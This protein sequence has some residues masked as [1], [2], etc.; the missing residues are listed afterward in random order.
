M[1]TDSP[2]ALTA[3]GIVTALGTGAAEVWPRLIEGDQSGLVER[4]D[5]VPGRRMVAAAV[6]D[7][8]PDVGA[9]LERYRCRNNALALAA[10]HQ[11]ERPVRTMLAAVGAERVAV[12][13]GS[14]TAGVA[15]AETAM[16]DH[17]ATGELPS[18]FHYIQFEFG[19]V[20]E[21]VAEW[22]GA[23]GPAY[24]IST[25]CS[26]SAKAIASARSLLRLG[27]CDAAI[28]GGADSLCRLTAN[29]FTALQAISE[30]PCN[31]F[32]A[33][34][35][36]LT[37]GEGAAIFLL[38]RTPGGIQLLGVGEATEAYHMSAP[39]PEGRGAEGAMRAALE[40]AGVEPPAIVYVNLHGTGT[41]LNDAME[42]KAVSRVFSDG[43]CCS[44]TK[45][46]LGHTL[47]AAG[48]IEVAVC[49]MILAHPQGQRIDVPP[50]LWDG[51]PDPLLPPLRLAETVGH[52]CSDG[53]ALLLT[54][55][56]AFG[57]NDCSLILGRESSS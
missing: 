33:N 17:L 10:L 49:W 46:M 48:A 47:G 22:A 55:S 5:L 3:L 45:P 11:I 24:T 18:D 42:A 31:P 21:F 41:L 2:C 34:R 4:T 51:S 52:A 20:A 28:A 16:R 43:V 32:S 15:A 1:P 12:V 40:D 27:L 44:S 6:R 36:G 39:E 53:S 54:N 26:S 57:G 13:M 50:H 29:G 37:L 30:G 23:R 9:G 38:T 25:A 19:G 8:L 7:P 56:F 14:S 35:R